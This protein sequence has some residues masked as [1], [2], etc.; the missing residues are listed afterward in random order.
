MF[1]TLF[2]CGAL[3]GAD[4]DLSSP[5]AVTDFSA[6]ETARRTIG[7]D[8]DAHVRLALWC[9]SHGL[10]SERMK[11]LALAVMYDPSHAL[12][13]GLLGMV[14]YQGK[15][16]PPGDVGLK[17]DRD[18]AYREAMREYLDRRARTGDKADAQLKLAAWCEEKG[19][20]PQA[21]THYEQV[22]QLDPT[23]EAAWKH[24]GFK[25]QGNRWVKPDQAAAEKQDA[26][27]QKLADKHWRP[28][29]E[30]LRD[31]LRS[32]DSQR[33][34]RADAALADVN[35]PRAVPMISRLFLFGSEGSQI[36]AISMLSHIEGPAATSGLAALAIFSPRPDVQRRAAQSLNQ[37]DLRDIMNRLI[38][39]IRKPFKYQVRPVSGPGST[40]V[41]FVEGEKF[42][43]QRVYRSMP[44]NLSSMPSGA[45]S[46]SAAIN[47][48]ASSSVSPLA[49]EN[50]LAFPANNGV[51]PFELL[52]AQVRSSGLSSADVQAGIRQLERV[53]EAN[54][55]LQQGLVQDVLAIEAVNA[56][57][58]QV[59]ERILP[60][61]EAASGQ[62]IGVEPEKW[63]GWWSDQ[64]GY[65]F[66]A[67]Q[68]TTKPTFTDFVDATSSWS[69]SLECFGRGTLVHAAGGT[70]P[71]ETIQ[72]G[73]RVL[74]QNTSTGVLSYQPVMV[75]HRT[76][77]AGTFRIT[78][79][80]DTITATG[81]HRFWKAGQGWTM[82]RDL[83]AGDR[84]RIPGGLVEVRSVAG[85][86][87]QT[88][89]NL[90]VAENHDFFVGRQGILVHDSNFVKPV[91]E[92]FDAPEDLAVI[93]PSAKVR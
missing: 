31:D 11:H 20:K 85:D 62:R 52:A 23:R 12:A 13:R 57:I 66:Q 64:L 39:L 81:I 19:L 33:R 38:G 70:R 91:P 76:A 58:N 26:E 29:L 75:V 53:R 59:N 7:R 35:D 1:C 86:K 45:Q 40:G 68:P 30:K 17:I 63:K 93:T 34:A 92:P 50:Q 4:P 89:F 55:S 65:Q 22:I 48:G 82:A 32:K 74:S 21:I 84:L 54:T 6:Y 18:P 72:A 67:S 24:L 83:K 42:N 46:L 3:L 14:S 80:G 25:K 60:I 28:I 49:L 16:G 41:L 71:I 5:K 61:I 73:D 51:D 78:L 8:P 27:R 77:S 90:D 15:W 36:A 43:I 47:S 2:L 87:N 9:E 44:I 88:V 37:R 56:Q 69:A 79:D 10:R